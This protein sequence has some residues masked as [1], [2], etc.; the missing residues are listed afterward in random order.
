[1]EAAAGA[2]LRATV[3]GQSQRRKNQDW[4]ADLINPK[5][6]DGTRPCISAGQDLSRS[7]LPV[8]HKFGSPQ[9]HERGIILVSQTWVATTARESRA[10]PADLALPSAHCG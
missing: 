6:E 8:K 2:K 1:M 7:Q 10:L 9:S 3:S 5:E 4:R